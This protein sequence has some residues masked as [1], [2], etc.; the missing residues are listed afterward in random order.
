MSLRSSR[1]RGRRFSLVL[2]LSVAL[3]AGA[4][5][6]RLR[7]QASTV[8]GDANGDTLVDVNDVFFLINYLFASGPAPA[9][10]A[11]ANGDG[12]VDVN[13]VFVLVNYLFAGGPAPVDGPI[14]LVAIS[15]V[16]YGAPL[17]AAVILQF[18]RPLGTAFST[19]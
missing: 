4:E 2:L 12:H 5:T 17:N 8:A 9:G 6:A 15:P 1:V 18:N 13:D 10:P 14:Q 3:G 19:L 11:D 16:S 7:A